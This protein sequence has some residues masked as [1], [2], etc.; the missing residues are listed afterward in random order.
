MQTIRV[1]VE[2][3]RDRVRLKAVDDKG[4]AEIIIEDILRGDATGERNRLLERLV[5][6]GQYDEVTGGRIQPMNNQISNKAQ[7]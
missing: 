7:K 6:S 4:R 2:P 1:T 3:A 5:S